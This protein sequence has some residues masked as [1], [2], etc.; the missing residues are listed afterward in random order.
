MGKAAG[1]VLPPS[2]TL[3]LFQF[4]DPVM[5]RFFWIL[6]LFSQAATGQKLKK[7][8]KATLA[9]LQ[10]HIGFLADDRLQGRRTGTPGEAAAAEY[11]SAE[12][13]ARGLQ[14]MGTGGSFLQP[15]P[16]DD[17]K[18]VLPASFCIINEHDLKLH[19]DYF[20]FPNSPKISG[21]YTTAASLREAGGPWFIDIGTLADEEKNNPH[22]DLNQALRAKTEE[23]LKNKATAV[24]FY[25]KSKA[26]DRIKFE[27][28]SK[29][30][31]LPL[32][33]FYLTREGSA[34]VLSEESALLDIKFKVALENK[35]R[36]GNNVVGFIS[37]GAPTT[38]VIGA[39]YDHLGMGEDNN[40]LFSG[41]QGQIHNGA[42]DNASG[43]AAL[44]ELSKKLAES[45]YKKNNYLLVAFSGEELGLNGSKY[46]ADNCPVAIATVNYMVNLDM[47]GRLND[48]SRALTLGG[49]GTSPAWPALVS[50][51]SAM[52][53]FRFD[54]SGTGPSDH[55][56]FYRKNIPVLFLFTGLHTD[57]HKPSDDADKINY[58]G[59]L[60]IVKFVYGVVEAADGSGKLAF[61]KTRESSMAKSTFRVSLG[62]MPDYTFSGSGVRVDGVSEG[63]A[64]QKAGIR[65]GDVLLQL[66]EHPFTDVQSYMGAL[67]RFSKGEATR[68][69]VLR[70]KETLFF[71]IVF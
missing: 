55:T 6:L 45:K 46:F 33:V 50:N 35:K 56:S 64:A 30:A 27:P 61:T 1:R 15:F 58:F 17:G 29:E 62:I 44:I 11:I 70:G 38:V 21:E 2:K 63:K 19:R 3:P 48:S 47:V 20:P 40:S 59:V 39:H 71:D 49:Y 66:G 25:N 60:Q 34:K 13:A 8:D 24:F 7:A 26:E 18:A 28:R 22:F 67:N 16:V 65:A 23:A 10:T 52:F 9:A 31:E 51:G 68:V 32:P 53:Q 14:P 42:D 41:P 57:Y 36:T 12:F 69:K 4:T 43:T 5:K 37:N 54:S